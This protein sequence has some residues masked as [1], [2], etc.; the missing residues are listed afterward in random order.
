M[1]QLILQ[2]IV[3]LHRMRKAVFKIIAFRSHGRKGNITIIRHKGVKE[4]LTL[5]SISIITVITLEEIYFYA[6]DDLV[7]TS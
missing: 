1:G 3:G 7:E 4:K 6:Y 2:L 5:L